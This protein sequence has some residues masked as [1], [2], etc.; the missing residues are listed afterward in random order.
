MDLKLLDL[1][2]NF[3]SIMLQV[4]LFELEI[5]YYVSLNSYLV[6]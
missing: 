1:Q 4:L 2:Y 6:F 5:Y 3:E